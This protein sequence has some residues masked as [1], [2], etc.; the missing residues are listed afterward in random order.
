MRNNEDG[1]KEKKKER[2]RERERKKNGSFVVLQRKSKNR[3]SR[4]FNRVFN[5]VFQDIDLLK[6]ALLWSLGY[7]A[8]SEG[9]C[10]DVG[11][12]S[13]RREE[14]K[15]TLVFNGVDEIDKNIGLEG[16]GN[17]LRRSQ[18]EAKRNSHIRITHEI[19]K[20]VLIVD[21]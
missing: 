19:N 7:A 21:K 10:G 4:D 15:D 2:R 11:N 16:I 5:G 12:R 9:L 3:R 20:L 18:G 14:F 8:A 13:F 6:T 17:D 1:E